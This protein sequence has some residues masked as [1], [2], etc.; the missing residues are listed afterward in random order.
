MTV[1][2]LVVLLTGIRWLRFKAYLM[3]VITVHCQ[4][5]STRAPDPVSLNGS[6]ARFL[7]VVPLFR[8]ALVGPTW[9]VHR[10]YCIL[11]Q[12]R[13]SILPGI[14]EGRSSVSGLVQIHG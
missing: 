13:E 9:Y 12:R 14:M 8:L 3:T 2:L 5:S 11:Y 4:H 6:V 7:S 1:I 10:P